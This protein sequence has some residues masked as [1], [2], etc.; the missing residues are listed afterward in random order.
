MVKL[1]GNGKLFA[2]DHFKG[3]KNKEQFYKVNNEDLSD[4]KGI[5]LENIQKSE[6][7]D[8][9]TLID[10]P[11]HE[12][13]KEIEDNSV[14]LIFIDGDHSREGVLNDIISYKKKLKKNSI[15]VF[16]DYNQEKFPELVDVVNEFVSKEKIGENILYTPHLWVELDN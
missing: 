8:Y 16:D 5:F 14:R 11:S 1:S 4:L 3:N 13:S 10:K 15:I 12:A 7:E 2:I 9:V 6:L